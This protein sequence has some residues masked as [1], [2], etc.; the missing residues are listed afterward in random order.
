[1]T[2]DSYEPEFVV[3][4][5]FY[6]EL[7]KI[8]YTM[9]PEALA[10]AVKVNLSARKAGRMSV[11]EMAS[12]NDRSAIGGLIDNAKSWFGGRRVKKRALRELESRRNQLNPSAATDIEEQNRRLKEIARIRNAEREI[13]GA[14]KSSKSN[15]SFFS[16]SE[17]PRRSSSLGSVAFGAGLGG[18]GLYGAQR[19][20][21]SRNQEPQY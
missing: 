8:A 2:F 6:D 16:S 11:G 10:E 17:G 4:Q 12:L 1:M 18:A 9:N 7:Q 3:A 14:G 19:Y 13:A 15:D 5:A 20:L 21:Q